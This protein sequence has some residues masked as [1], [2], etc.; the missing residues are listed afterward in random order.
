[1]QVILRFVKEFE[2]NIGIKITC[3]KDVEPMGTTRSLSLSRDKLD[4]ESGEPFFVLNNDVICKYSCLNFT[5][6]MGG[7]PQLWLQR[8]AYMPYSSLIS[9]C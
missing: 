9:F 8:H 7:R 4:D 2:A 6:I 1:M 5:K 3:S